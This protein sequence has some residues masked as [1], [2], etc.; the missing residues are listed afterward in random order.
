MRQVDFIYKLTSGNSWLCLVRFR[1]VRVNEAKY[2][3]LLQVSDFILKSFSLPPSNYVLPRVGC[4]SY[5]TCSS[6]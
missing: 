2:K 5:E 1:I 6:E 3:C 4:V